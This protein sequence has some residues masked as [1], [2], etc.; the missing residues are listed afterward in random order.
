LGRADLLKQFGPEVLEATAGHPWEQTLLRLTLGRVRAKEGLA[1]AA[2]S[3]E[4]CQVLYYAGARLLT[5]GEG[6]QAR[7]ILGQC[8]AES[9]ECLERRLAQ[10]ELA[11]SATAAPGDTLPLKQLNQQIGRLHQQGQYVAALAIARQALDLARQ[12]Q[13]EQH[14][15]TARSLN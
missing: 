4:R 14:P 7:Q 13:G 8:V 6:G 1:Q 5:L 9:A 3:A 10:L 11:R 2:D 12:L 15:D